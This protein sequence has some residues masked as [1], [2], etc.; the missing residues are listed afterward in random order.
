VP[1]AVGV[2]DGRATCV[3]LACP[4]AASDSALGAALAV[5]RKLAPVVVTTRAEGD[6]PLLSAL[7]ATLGDVA[8][9]AGHIDAAPWTDAF[10]GYARAAADAS[11]AGRLFRNADADVL[12]IHAFGFPRHL[13]G[14]LHQVRLREAGDSKPGADR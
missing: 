14:P 8:S 10:A 5:A 6:T 11:A 9:A 1:A 3:E 2:R 13:G 4:P 7:A 12:A